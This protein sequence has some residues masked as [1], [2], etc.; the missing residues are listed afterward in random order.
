MSNDFHDNLSL[1]YI[2]SETYNNN[3]LSIQNFVNSINEMTEANA[4][5]HN[6]IIELLNNMNRSYTNRTYRNR[7]DTNRTYPNRT[8]TNRTYPNRFDNNRENRN[9][10]INR[11][12]STSTNYS[13]AN[14]NR[15][16][17]QQSN[18]LGRVI[19]NNIPYIID[20]VQHY[21]IPSGNENTIPDQTR[22]TGFSRLLQNFFQPVEIYPTQSQIEASTR[23]V[24]YC[25][26]VNPTNISCP[27]SL[28]NFSD[29]DN[30]TVIR[31]CGHIFNP[32]QLTM[33]FRSNCRCPVCRYDIR[34]YNTNYNFSDPSENNMS[35]DM[36]NNQTD[37]PTDDPNDDETTSVQIDTEIDTDRT[38]VE[39]NNEEP[40]PTFTRRSNNATSRYRDGS[41]YFD[42]FFSDNTLLDSFSNLSDDRDPTAILALLRAL[43]RNNR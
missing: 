40:S 4:H 25:D 28:E 14:V 26:I 42:L 30:V 33:W 32:Q 27:I 41:T 19:L 17:T 39:R 18:N 21:R 2:L 31:H 1:I 11:S 5:I 15:E 36:S 16:N 29:T 10:T 9:R 22:N 12:A 34:N 35:T 43:Q 6:R 38:E 13:T 37:Y 7:T 20:S 24:R 8:D 23:N 3:L